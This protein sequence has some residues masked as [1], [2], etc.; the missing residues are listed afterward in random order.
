MFC[1]ARVSMGRALVKE[2][3]KELYPSLVVYVQ[4]NIGYHTKM[5]NENS[6]G[7]ND[8]NSLKIHA[9]ARFFALTAF[10]RQWYR[11]L[12]LSQI[13]HVLSGEED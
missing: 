11:P 4:R 13:F 3:Q 8:H 10:G 5:V 6:A 2:S 1:E 7:L 12:V 9:S